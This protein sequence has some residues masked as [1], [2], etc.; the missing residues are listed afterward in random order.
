MAQYAKESGLQS[1][2][3]KP[4]LFYSKRIFIRLDWL[5][6]NQNF[7]LAFFVQSDGR[8]CNKPQT[9]GSLLVLTASEWQKITHS[10]AGYV[11]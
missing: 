10:V 4:D 7:I 11:F 8:F 2:D 9:I 1:L 6:F 5:I 3:C